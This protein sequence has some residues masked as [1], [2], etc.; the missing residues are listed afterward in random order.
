MLVESAVTANISA[1]FLRDVC[2]RSSRRL[3]RRWLQAR[4]LR[5][6]PLDALAFGV[7]QVAQAFELRNQLFNFRKRGPGDA[8]DQ[9]VDVVDGRLG[10]R[11]ER[12]RF[13][14]GLER[15]AQMGDIVAHEVADAG[16]DFRDRS[17]IAVD[18]FRS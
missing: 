13:R 3:H 10:V 1:N 2:R 16:L 15:A 17:E 9:R 14:A 18:I 6:H 12:S 8:L 5:N 7:Q 11:F 4:L